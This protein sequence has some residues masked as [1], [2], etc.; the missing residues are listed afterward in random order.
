[1]LSRAPLDTHSLNGCPLRRHILLSFLNSSLATFVS[2][3]DAT[4]LVSLYIC[5]LTHRDAQ[6]LVDHIDLTSIGF[7]L[8]NHGANVELQVSLQV[9][10]IEYLQV[11]FVTLGLAARKE[12]TA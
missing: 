3:L 1:M 8:F 9:T 10:L 6:V 5:R 11:F 2:D 4:N 12:T 7:L